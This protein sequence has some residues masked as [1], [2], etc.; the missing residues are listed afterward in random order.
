MDTK[1]NIY[2]FFKVISINNNI[3]NTFELMNKIN[4]NK[5]ILKSIIYIKNY[6]TFK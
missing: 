5:Y 6:N 4:N 3:I 2:I 1:D